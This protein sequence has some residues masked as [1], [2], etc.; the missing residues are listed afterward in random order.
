MQSKPVKC[1]P[2]DTEDRSVLPHAATPEQLTPTD[3][4]FTPVRRGW[5]GFTLIVAT[6]IFILGWLWL[7]IGLALSLSGF[8]AA[9]ARSGWYYALMAASIVAFMVVYVGKQLDAPPAPAAISQIGN[10]VIYESSHV[11]LTLPSDWTYTT[12]NNDTM[13]AQS[14]S[15]LAHI[16]M[17]RVV[18]PPHLGGSVDATMRKLVTMDMA[19]Y[20]DFLTPFFPAA[21]K[22]EVLEKGVTSL[23]KQNA[24]FAKYGATVSVLGVDI[25][26]V[27][28]SWV[29]VKD[30]GIYDIRAVASDR[31]FPQWEPTLREAVAT[32]T[33]K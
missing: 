19:T 4:F 28:L 16:V 31:E 27:V 6:G 1:D 15:G 14:H 3:G 5:I 7:Y 30:G 18:T 17:Y 22:I 8:W 24:I 9:R 13:E 23:G 21:K 20:G 25:E 32:T 10:Q 12:P 33:W 26:Y 11:R 2:D 29:V